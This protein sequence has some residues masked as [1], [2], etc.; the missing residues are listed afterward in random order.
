MMCSS[1][2]RAQLLI[3]AREEGFSVYTASGASVRLPS[4]RRNTE[5]RSR[6]PVHGW[7]CT[8]MHSCRNVLSL[9]FMEQS[10]DIVEAGV[11]IEALE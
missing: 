10:R 9:V 2:S 5:Q 8:H 4:D 6:T 7:T 3:P 11:G 1:F